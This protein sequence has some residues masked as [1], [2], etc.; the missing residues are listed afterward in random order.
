MSCVTRNVEND[1]MR[2]KRA[3]IQLI[4]QYGIQFQEVGIFGSYARC[5]YKS[6]S[7]IDFCIITDDRP[8]RVISGSLREDAEL[9]GADIVFVTPEYFTHDTSEFARQLR[10]DYRRVL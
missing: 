6:T 7:D 9:L 4:K 10:R 2:R 8:T 1:F 3:V 5:C